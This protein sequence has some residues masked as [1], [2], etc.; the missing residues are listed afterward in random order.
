MEDLKDYWGRLFPANQ[1]TEEEKSLAEILPSMRKE[2]RHLICNRCD[3]RVANYLSLLPVGAYY[4]RQCLA[5]GRIRSDEALYYFPQQPFKGQRALLWQGQLTPWQKKLSEELRRT[6]KE[7]RDCLVHAVTGA[8]KT[9]MVYGLI[10]DAL[11][12]GKAIC[13]ASPRIDVCLELYDR[14]KRDFSC[15]I[16]L[17]HGGGE[18][19]VRSPLVIATTH[20]LLKFYQAFDLLIVDEVDAF[21]FVDNQMLYH[22]VEKSLKTDGIRVFL[23]ATTTEELDKKV[24]S[25]DLKLLRLPRRFHEQALVVPKKI[26]LGH[27][28]KCLSRGRLP[29]KLKRAIYRQLETGFPL[30]IFVAE[31]SIGKQ[32]TRLLE[33]LLTTKAVGFVSS[34]AEERLEIVAAF[35]KG[36]LGILVSTSILERGVTFPAVDVFVLEANHRLFTKSSLVQIAGRVGRS[37]E[38]PTGLL[39]FYHDGTNQA[40][41]KAIAEIK[42]MNKESGL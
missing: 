35:R 10:A 11:N 12:L 42:L 28:R 24:R 40:I 16:A 22:A 17:L 5:L 8:G 26:W 14:L 7:G 29:P 30:L 39:N 33:K 31:I 25:G 1:L 32:L 27:F 9:E 4:C 3:G 6:F 2:K 38:R 18:P 21:P 13:L 41:E 15:S 37:K 23:T 19:Y 34:Q 20:Q 36:E